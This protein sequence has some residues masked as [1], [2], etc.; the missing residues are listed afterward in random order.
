MWGCFGITLNSSWSKAASSIFPNLFCLGIVSVMSDVQSPLPSVAISAQAILAQP[1]SECLPTLN[2]FREYLQVTFII[3]C[4]LP[5]WC[6]ISR[7]RIPTLHGYGMTTL[8]GYGIKSATASVSTPWWA[9]GI[10]SG[11]R[12]QRSENMTSRDCLGRCRI[13]SSASQTPNVVAT[14]GTH[15]ES[16]RRRGRRRCRRR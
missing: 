4:R 1:S 6:R 10:S 12:G 7:F 3:P 16:R 11:K 9:F 5:T 2:T 13:Q 15:P 8:H 14:H